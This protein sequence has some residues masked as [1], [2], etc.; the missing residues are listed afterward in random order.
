MPCIVAPQDPAAREVIEAGAERLF[1][2]LKIGRQDW[3]SRREGDSL[4][5]Q[6]DHG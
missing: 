5:Y 6:D 2:P 3:D 1:A 4:I